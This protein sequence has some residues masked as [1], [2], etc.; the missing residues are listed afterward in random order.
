MDS[1]L[2]PKFGETEYTREEVV[3]TVRKYLCSII[4]RCPESELPTDSIVLVCGT[5]ALY[6]RLFKKNPS[7]ADLDRQVQIEMNCLCSIPEFTKYEKCKNPNENPTEEQ[8]KILED[9]SNILK[10]ESRYV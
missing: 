9:Y 8:A 4:F 10:L 2:F 3:S 1:A 7:R 5:W 6:A